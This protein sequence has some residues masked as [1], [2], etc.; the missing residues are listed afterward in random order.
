[1]RFLIIPEDNQI[2]VFFQNGPFLLE[3]S[4]HTAST[5]KKQA[6]YACIFHT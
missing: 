2:G 1:M 4:V 5:R 3:P 6:F